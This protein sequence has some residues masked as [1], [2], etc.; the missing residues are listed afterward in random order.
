MLDHMSYLS[1]GQ[2][3]AFT[4]PKADPAAGNFEL[5]GHAAD[6]VYLR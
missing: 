5:A 6:T 2:F 4:R 3:S 1:E